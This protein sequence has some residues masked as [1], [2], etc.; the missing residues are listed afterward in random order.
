MSIRLYRSDGDFF[1]FT[2]S[3]WERLI[4]FARQYGCEA[5]GLARLVDWNDDGTG[6][7]E[8]PNM[9]GVHVVGDAEARALAEAA[10]RGLADPDALVLRRIV[11]EGNVTLQQRR[12]DLAF[13][14]SHFTEPWA[15]FVT[16]ARAGGFRLDWMD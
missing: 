14:I 2:S 4:N 13:T 9:I 10:D 6:S 11:A 1:W 16:F 3:N 8:G 5:T 15:K 7:L 12:P